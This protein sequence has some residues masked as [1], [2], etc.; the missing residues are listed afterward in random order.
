MNS[1]EVRKGIKVID[2]FS[3]ENGEGEIISVKEN[4]TRVKYKAYIRK[5]TDIGLADLTEKIN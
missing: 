4:E 1:R 3:P 5:Y 2:R